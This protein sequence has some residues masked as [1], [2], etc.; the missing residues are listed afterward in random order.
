MQTPFVLTP[1]K[2][3][4]V[5]V[6]DN[7]GFTCTGT[8]SAGTSYYAFS[9]K[10]TAN[11]SSVYC[12]SVNGAGTLSTYGTHTHFTIAGGTAD[13]NAVALF[14]IESPKK[15]V[16]AAQNIPVKVT[17][18]NNGFKDLKNC[19][20]NWKVNEVLQTPFYWSG[21]LPD[22]FKDTGI[23][24]GS[25][26]PKSSSYDT[27]VVWVGMPNG[28]LDTTNV[29]D[30]TLSIITYGCVNQL[31][32]TYI[33]GSQTGANFASYS[34]AIKIL[35]NC[36][37]SG[38]ITFKFQNG[39]YSP[40]AIGDL[41]KYL[42]AYSL[43]ITSLSG[44]RSDVIFQRNTGDYAV[45]I[46]GTQNII[47][48]DVSIFNLLTSA[49]AN[50][51]ALL[52]TGDNKNIDI[53]NCLI[54]MD[55]TVTSSYFSAVYKTSTG[56][57][58]NVR[59]I[60][61]TIQG[62]YYGFYLYGGNANSN[63]G[64]NLVVDSNLIFGQYYY[65]T[66]FYYG[67]FNSISNNIILSRT[68]NVGTNWYGLRT[69]YCN[70]VANGNKVRQRS[71]SITQ[72]YLIYSYYTSYYN[73]T[74][75]SLLCNNEA[76]GYTTGSYYG[77]YFNNS[78]LDVFNNSVMLRGSSTSR[79]IYI[80]GTTGYVTDC[81]NNN[82]LNYSTSGY[83]IYVNTTGTY[84]GNYNNFY[85]KS[86]YIGYYSGNRTTMSDWQTA[87][88][89]DANSV[90]IQTKFLGDSTQSLKLID[91]T[92]ITCPS[93]QRVPVD[94]EGLVR[95]GNTGIGAYTIYPTKLNAAALGAANWDSSI[96][97]GNSASVNVIIANVGTDSLVSVIV[98]W[99]I[100]GVIQPSV[101]WTGLLKTYQKDT[102]YLGLTYPISGLN[103]IQAWTT[104]PNNG[105][106]DNSYNDTCLFKV[107]GCDSLY[108]GSY[109]V[110][111][112]GADFADMNTAIKSIYNCGISGPTVLVL[113]SGIYD[114]LVFNKN[115]KG[116]S[117]KNT[118]TITSKTG[119]PDDVKF[120]VT[121]GIALSLE[122]VNNFYFKN[123]TFDATAPSDGQA[124]NMKGRC[125]NVEFR[126]CKILASPTTSSTSYAFYKMSGSACDSIRLKN[127][128]ISGGYYAL[129]FYGLGTG[130]G[131][132]NTNIYIDSNIIEDA[133]YNSH[134]IYYTDLNSFS[135][136]KIT[137]RK[138]GNNYHYMY[139]YYT[140]HYNTVCNTYN[141][142]NSS[143]EYAYTYFYYSQYYNFNSNGL[144][145]NNQ[146]IHSSA[147]KEG[148]GMYLG[149]T[150]G[151]VKVYNNSIYI[152]GT[153][154]Y[155]IY[156]VCSS[157]SGTFEIANN[158]IWSNQYPI[159]K[160][161]TNCTVVSDYNN[162]YSTGTY[163]GYFN[164]PCTSMSAW[165]TASGDLTSV[166]VAPQYI[167]STESLEL[168]SAS[169]LSCP[170]LQGVITD[171]SGLSRN[172][173]TTMGCYEFNPKNYDVSLRLITS[174]SGTLISGNSTQTSVNV[175]NQGTQTITSI[176]IY[177][178]VNGVLKPKYSWTGTL[179]PMTTI[180]I[181]IGNFI[182]QVGTNTI[183]IWTDSPN[184]QLD[185]NTLNDTISM[186][187]T[188]CDS[189]LNGI[190]TVG[191][192]GVFATMSALMTA[193]NNCGIGGPVTIKLLPGKYSEMLFTNT[194]PGTDSIKTITFTSYHNNVDSVIIESTTGTEATIDLSG[195]V[196]NLIFDQLTVN[197]CMIS[198]S[199]VS[200]GFGLNDCEN[201][202][203]KRCKIN[204]LPDE[205]HYQ[206]YSG[207][208][209]PYSGGQFKNVLV[210]SCII[211][212]PQY[213]VY[214]EPGNNNGPFYFR[215]NIVNT[216]YVCMTTY[217]ASLNDI[218]YNTFTM[219][220]TSTRTSF[221]IFECYGKGSNDPDTMWLVGNKFRVSVPTSVS[222]FNTDCYFESFYPAKAFVMANNEFYIPNNS[223][224]SSA[225][226]NFDDVNNVH[227]INNTFLSYITNS[228]INFDY[229]SGK[230]I[231][232]NNNLVGINGGSLVTVNGRTITESD[233]NNIY[234]SSLT[235]NAWK[236][237]TQQDTHSV[238]ISPYFINPSINLDLLDDG[239]LECPREALAINDI[240]KSNRNALT[241][242]GA[243]QV[244]SVNNNLI[245][246][247]MVSP[248]FVSIT[249]V[250]TPVT[251]T[252]FNAGL[253]TVTSMNVYWSVNGVAQTTY[254]WTGS[255]ASKA[256]VNINLGSFV[257]VK[258]SNII[259]VYTS[260]PNGLPDNI[261][262]NDTLRFYTKGCDSLLQG[263]YIVSSSI[264]LSN[265]VDKLFNC[266]VKGPVVIKLATG[267]YDPISLTKQF[268]GTS[269]I[270]T[271]TFTSLANNADSVI[272]KTT[273]STPALSLN[274]L[275]YVK[276]DNITFDGSNTDVYTVQFF[277]GCN[278][279][280]FYK[281]K[282]LANPTTS[283]SASAGIYKTSS[284]NNLNNVSFIKNYING[285]YYGI[286]IYSGTGTGSYGKNIIVDSN[287]IQNAYYYSSYF[288]YTAFKSYS[289]N[290]LYSRSS[291]T[292]TYWYGI[293]SYYCN[294]T[295]AN[296]NKIRQRSTAITYPY[297]IYAYYSNYS[298]YTSD[299][300][301]FMNN[302]IILTTASTYYGIYM[303]YSTVR[304]YH[305]SVLM[306]GSGA[307]RALYLSGTDPVDIKNNIFVTPSGGHP[308]Y[309]G[310][311]TQPM[312][313]DYN[314]LY[315]A[316]T[317]VGYN[318]TNITSLS[319]WRTVTGQDNH[320]VSIAPSFAA[321]DSNYLM[322]NSF[323]GM[324]APIVN[325]ATV[326]I[327][328][329][330]RYGIT[331]MGAYTYIPYS[332]DAAMIDIVNWKQSSVIGTLTPVKAVLMNLSSST[333]ITS[334]IINWTVRGSLQTAYNWTGSLSQY[335]TDTI[336]LG[337]FYPI[338]GANDIVVWCTNPNYGTDLLLSNDTVKA[339]T[340]GCDSLLHG[341]Y[342]VGGT[343]ASFS[344]IESAILALEKCGISGP[345]E[346]YL[347]A[348][349]YGQLSLTSNIV[350]TSSVN[351]ITFISANKNPLSVVFTSS[352]ALNIMNASNMKFKY[353]SFGNGTGSYA[354]YMMGKCNNLE[355]YHC[356]MQLSTT[357]TT[358]GTYVFY[359][360]QGATC[361]NFKFIGNVV[362]GGYYGLYFQGQGTNSG[363]Y[364]TNVIIDSNIFS[365]AY[366]Y[367][368]YLYYLD[369]PSF[370][371]NLITPRASGTTNWN[372]YITYC[373]L[374]YA[375][376]NRWNTMNSST[377]T[378]FYNY[379]Q[380]CNYYNS[381]GRGYFANNEVIN[382][383]I[384]GGYG[385]YSYNSNIDIL[386]NSILTTGPSSYS[387]YLDGTG[388]QMTLKDN[389]V[390]AANVPMNI[391]QG[392]NIALSTNCYYSTSG[393]ISMWQGTNYFTLNDWK[394]ISG[395]VNAKFI[396]PYFVDQTQS[397]E[398]V[399]YTGFACDRLSD[400][401][402]D[403]NNNP[404]SSITTIGANSLLLYEGF[405][406]SV[407]EITE[408]ALFTVVKCYPDFSTIKA[409][410]YNR[411]TS[412]ID[413]SVDSAIIHVKVTGAMNFQM[414]TII[415]KGIIN[416]LEKD[417]LTL[418]NLMPTSATGEY[419]I[420]V[421]VTC[422]S[423]AFVNDDTAYSKYL[424]ERVTLPY[425]VY[426]D[427]V[428]Q[429]MAFENI[430]GNVGWEV[431][432]STGA[433][434][435]A[436]F[437]DGRLAF[438]SSTGLGSMARAYI[439]QVDLQGT[440][441][442]MLNFWYQHDNNNPN[443]LD[444]TDIIVS[445]DG[446]LTY[447]YLYT[448]K[449]YDS[450]ATTPFWKIH[451]VDLSKYI[452][453]TCLIVGFEA[454]SYGG[455]DQIIDRIFLEVQQDLVPKEIRL[456]SELYAC[457]LVNKPI[458]VIVANTTV[459]AVQMDKD[460][461][462]L[463]F[464]ITTPDNITQKSTYRFLG[465]IPPMSSDTI[466][467]HSGF[468]FSKHG[469][470]KMTAYI[471]TIKITTDISNDTI[472]HVIDINPDIQIT[473]IKSI[474]NKN[475]RDT[476]F[477]QVTVKNVGN[478][479]AYEIP[480][481]LQ[482][483]NSNDIVEK[484]QSPLAPGDS[485]DYI[486]K[487]PFIVPEVNAIQ[488]YYQIS[489]AS[490]MPCDEDTL[491]SKYKLISGVNLV[492]LVL[493]SIDE[494]TKTDCD[495]GF[496]NVFV[497]VQLFNNGDSDLTN[498]KV[499]VLIDSASITIGNIYQI[500][501]SVPIGKQQ[502]TF[503]TPYKVPNLTG[504]YKITVFIETVS[505]DM[506]L[507][508]DTLTMD[509]CAILNETGIDKINIQTWMMG[510]NLPNPAQKTTK[511]PFYI[512]QDGSIIVKITSVTGQIL[513]QENLIAKTGENTYLLNLENLSSGIYYYSMEYEGK[514]Q[515][516]KLTVQR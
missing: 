54:R 316:G 195:G 305:N 503:T 393:I 73:A 107:Y 468:D 59:F 388:S 89:Q 294:Y 513:F 150:N 173:T 21:N 286:Y 197:G 342:T 508:N 219:D 178:T 87:C 253:N 92:G 358:S 349:N 422:V 265:I 147:S 380:Y 309:M 240:R 302:E 391:Y 460:T 175:R 514:I 148:Y 499:R 38:N 367:P 418:T 169:G 496:L 168:L 512:P 491:N 494:P 84:S 376:G 394:N 9:F 251:V 11:N 20:I 324:F 318:N 5:Y 47:I 179:S 377:I 182:P 246:R 10:T 300:G 339:S 23:V 215:N 167:D 205:T 134:Y 236:V 437:G 128:I 52:F 299:T 190:Y 7:S 255:L 402:T 142:S 279:L 198:G 440:S 41:S 285:G 117:N 226:L 385:M 287:T 25:Y 351:T 450:A 438:K 320:S 399:S 99:S 137:P 172:Y 85:S 479:I 144:I 454:Q 280:D 187:F 160:T 96:V 369:I 17:I 365:N 106:D 162:L 238:S 449:R 143:I 338:G 105:I 213:G 244:N 211:K 260:L 67:D 461:I 206:E 314:N 46:T 125:V 250:T 408:P 487:N 308:I 475:V 32:G 506:N 425:D 262:L 273:T 140:N 81:R 296:A 228:Y 138:D 101:N 93:L 307:S 220:S 76:I 502:Y 476:V 33:I 331:T 335:A 241:S 68:A 257:P 366:Y 163:V 274:S 360:P 15:S 64:K 136:N 110:G 378:Y 245:P 75:R 430:Q 71:N 321:V 223:L 350:G 191:T 327:K 405:N 14:V 504:N 269:A 448:V 39:T 61:N 410:L 516:K 436:V 86:S 207:I 270:N 193:V 29:F 2:N 416:P 276:F 429:E 428:P 77:M 234:S 230:T 166:K 119:N 505:G 272:I 283:S 497:K 135:Y 177:W 457:E 364:N 212:N 433:V 354:V 254:P 275:S 353:L 348:G 113:N 426:F 3:L 112:T 26:V 42:G 53:L 295:I 192:G 146:F 290:N 72:P 34:A 123:V 489:V 371:H 282:I 139:F 203:I 184:N 361:D 224:I 237:I 452:N 202:I 216:R 248:S 158:N 446:G 45:N 328:G 511:I 387:I 149:Y 141:L 326:D 133:Y 217:N 98:N 510:Q 423:D 439:K 227:Y 435:P 481:R 130:V 332:L 181:T 155:G 383:S 79:C 199:S 176:N 1:G 337:N 201:I 111:G 232:K 323:T 395:D 156:A 66:F 303:P 4:L 336:T 301:L 456:P 333:P 488:P 381:S 90:R 397:L 129:Y 312:Y 16:I 486:F 153:A 473:K 189:L 325:P 424:V 132:Y 420:A 268:I 413:F 359:K 122:N 459:Y 83:P 453:A 507:K 432:D 210:D 477:A 161:G 396:K 24:I 401:L 291:N 124:V 509:A 63:Y 49:S 442:P 88:A 427:S 242:I 421:W 400:V 109:T 311:P 310:T 419:N 22:D 404:R 467:V 297:G 444:Q 500:F 204:I 409:S 95:A 319:S 352:P 469:S 343:G 431:V 374:Y 235:L 406:L 214:L 13:S 271:V 289:Y 266:G 293:S 412:Q 43:T 145:A 344:T 267:T 281:C 221:W 414:D 386:H 18:Q 464:E 445:T 482:I 51:Y 363:G 501:P 74:G 455:G 304:I 407:D 447:K 8:N 233:Y 370:S 44:N 347:A 115:I 152:S 493:F 218:S 120:V 379:M 91:Y 463:T 298:S 183:K 313:S 12:R 471:D 239:G 375:V 368:Y 490:E 292:N 259:V 157:G 209:C 108:H 40:I 495:T 164:L 340:Y 372:A 411:G 398:L 131:G 466:L 116:N 288:Y 498:V 170:M 121:T 222:S 434:I 174:P 357:S 196:G 451:Q 70:Y 194:I 69:Y 55:T 484:M 151:I 483:N 118:F 258:D 186:V 390:V 231:L 35:E 478:L 317:Y 362:N 104:L 515:V 356:E 229:G 472:R 127:N 50:T 334:V 80:G 277:G 373:N 261:P 330:G 415:S 103:T 441:K 389:L 185:E 480:L 188:A 19:I 37:A 114:A 403:F 100:N 200:A 78:A 126:N 6:Y 180:N 58:N 48:K 443:K 36:S 392:N 492:D 62:G 329:I 165:A 27:I 465:K 97:L 82:F 60:N 345:T 346:F 417:T 56:V 65:A 225:Y 252:V 382:K 470:Y 322:L 171:I 249:G 264:E 31:S 154:S 355:F 306:Q 102:L 208:Y 284:T 315:G 159:Y 458:E 247:S 474:G 278:N 384:N 57:L 30:D 485:I 263:A 341:V 256:F 243:Y 94:I 462:N 28:V